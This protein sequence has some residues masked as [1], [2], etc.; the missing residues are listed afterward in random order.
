MR[1]VRHPGA[2][3][4]ASAI[5]AGLLCILFILIAI[6]WIG[7]PGIQT[8]EALFAAGIYPPFS[9]QFAIRVFERDYPLM[10]MS[11][12]GALKS[13]IW[14]LIFKVWPPSP[15]SVRIPSVL[16]S[17]LSVWW[18]YRLLLRALG[19]R[20]AL[21]GAALLATDPLYLLYSRYDHG[22]VVLQHLCLIGAMLALVRFYQERRIIW[23]A[24]GFFML[25]VGL[26]DK[27]VFIWLFS[28][29]AVAAATVLW[30]PVRSALSR[31]NFV[32][33]ALACAIGASP[34]VIFNTNHDFVTLRSNPAWSTELI[35]VK[36]H[37][38]LSTLDGTVLFGALVRESTDGAIR[39]PST[40]A[41]KTVISVATAAGMPR[42]TL[43]RYLAAASI[44]L[45]PLVWR[46]PA[47]TAALFVLA[48][49]GVAWIQMACTKGTG[50]AAHHTIL[51]WPLPA[52]GIAAVLAEVSKKL[53]Y[54]RALL[55]SVVAI[56]CVSNLS[57]LSTY[58]ADLLRYGGTSSWTDAMYPALGAIR[59]MDKRAVCTIDWGFFDTLRMF[60]QGRTELCRA[61]DP[62]ND[63]GRRVALRQVSQ[64]G[65]V[66]L[67]HTEGN[68]AF[69]GVTAQY[70]QFAEAHGFRQV[71]RRVFADSHGRKTVETFEFERPSVEDPRS[72][73]TAHLASRPTALTT[74]PSSR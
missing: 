38:M 60:E 11:Y 34:L 43:M 73:A 21:A 52:I 22:P 71:R 4:R 19:T 49:L 26:W 42:R 31:R 16:L 65:T 10:V 14:S 51:L 61:V 24:G 53:H 2:C 64:P 39:E 20:A 41:E 46:T 62:A 17:A 68:E 67:T 5:T 33:A 72:A 8:D 69:P 28:G 30:G 48:A 47:R 50:V 25:G 44:L 15:A 27:A 35:S 74:T 9:E 70:V 7:K 12:V 63:E 37:Q 59:N 45:L 3:L 32:V 13:Y 54:G 1:L 57:V 40:V 29:L 58:Y 66:F 18:L 6:P 56:A 36:A 55:A 23:L